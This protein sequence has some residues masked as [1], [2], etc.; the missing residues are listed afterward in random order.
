MSI[1]F[2]NCAV[3]D[4]GKGELLPDYW[5]LV[6]GDIIREVS[7]RPIEAPGA[8][9]LDLAGRT[10]MPGLCDAHVHV[11]AVEP[12]LTK[13][14]RFSPSY[15]TARSINVLSGMLRRGF[16]TVRDAGGADQGLA[17]AVREGV[18]EG[19]RIMYSGR[20]ISQT[21]GHG[22]VRSPGEEAGN[23]CCP[24]VWALSRIGDGV[25]EVRRAARD[26]LRKG[27]CQIKIMVSGGVA[28]PSDRVTNTQFS[29]DEIR[30]I[31][32]EAQAADSYVMAHAYTARS[33]RRAL[34]CGVRSIEHGNLIDEETL[35]LLKEKE[36]FLVPTLCVYEMLYREGAASGISQQVLDKLGDLRENSLKALGM[37]MRKGV[38]IAFGTDLFGPFQEHQSLEFSLRREVCSPADMIRSAT[39]VCAELF[40]M[41]GR[42]GV[43]APGAYADL[44]AIDGDPLQS[45]ELLLEQGRHMSVIMKEG[46]FVVNRL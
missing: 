30:A 11:T 9:V 29:L 7:G 46:K 12:D 4:T 14:D 31:V 39:V 38:K 33:I 45:P 16:T 8:I 44:L 15:I 20:A 3:L 1:L 41:K 23:H 5:V 42:I 28:S 32:E 35:D 36:A 13:L 34:E 22:D 25:A 21:G 6:E 10:L 37:A 2:K 19:P 40:N 26:E 24:P 17:Q 43:I 27:A 18:C